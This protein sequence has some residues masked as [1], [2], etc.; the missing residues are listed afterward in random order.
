MASPILNFDKGSLDLSHVHP[1]E[2]LYVSTGQKP[3]LPPSSK[4]AQTILGR[5]APLQ[6]FS[7]L[8]PLPPRPSK[9]SKSSRF[10]IDN[11]ELSVVRL[12]G[13]GAGGKVY[14]AKLISDS[15]TPVRQLAL[16]VLDV[17]EGLVSTEEDNLREIPLGIAPDIFAT[18]LIRG[19]HFSGH[20]GILMEAYK[21]DLFFYGK[22]AFSRRINSVY[23]GN[24]VFFMRK[25]VVLLSKLHKE[26]FVHG[27]FKPLNIVYNNKDDVRIID[28]SSLFKGT[29]ANY[30]ELTYQYIPPE[31]ITVLYDSVT[32]EFKV[33]SSVD[34]S[35]DVWSFGVSLIEMLFDSPFFYEEEGDFMDY[36]NNVLDLLGRPPREFVSIEGDRERLYFHSFD[37]DCVRKFRP[38]EREENRS[39]EDV[40]GYFMN[41]IRERLGFFKVTLDAG[42]KI[43]G[44]SGEDF[45]ENLADLLSK[46]FR[47]KPADR[48][49]SEEILQ[50]PF[51]HNTRNSSVISLRC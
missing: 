48:I 28:Y 37:E 13:L 29:R 27:D 24:V 33:C 49:T 3:P 12:I 7:P 9:P 14:L 36:M 22:A 19:Y 40:R 38:L 2:P 50:H 21:G 32:S 15:A 34:S 47:W 17:V 23:L 41:Y 39:T 51:F 43:S 4:R 25:A 5:M 35:L 18:G 26:G 1:S 30:S 45:I 11:V 16:K 44:Q 42:V 20:H 8:P 6:R 10:K 31:S 46:I